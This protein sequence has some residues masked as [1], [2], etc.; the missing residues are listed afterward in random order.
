MSDGTASLYAMLWMLV[1]RLQVG[2]QS[3]SKWVVIC[4]GGLKLTR[5]DRD[6]IPGWNR[7]ANVV[8]CG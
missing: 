8:I 2:I 5:G 7:I 6:N 4:V 1:V 3:S